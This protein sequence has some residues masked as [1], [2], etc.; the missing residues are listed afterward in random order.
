MATLEIRLKKGR[1]GP[2]SFVL[3]RPDGSHTRQHDHTKGFFPPHDLTHFAVET[4]L[5]YR[6]GFYGIV[7]DGWDL[8]DF[9][10][11]W[12]KG[13]F[14]EDADPAEFIVGILDLERAAGERWTADQFNDA[15]RMKIGPS[16]VQFRP[17][18]DDDLGRIRARRA[19][20]VRQWNELQAGETLTLQFPLD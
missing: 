7:A 19:E 6:R 13:P 14:P 12:P 18:T 10:H 4:Q 3:I 2:H 1:D 15:L 11:P 5:G 9:G 17:L 8:K 16:P 20:L